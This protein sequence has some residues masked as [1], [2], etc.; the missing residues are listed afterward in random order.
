LAPDAGLLEVGIIGENRTKRMS[1][2]WY[3][4]LWI[5]ESIILIQPKYIMRE[6]ANPLLE[7]LLA[8]FRETR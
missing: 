6:E 8:H 3:M 4:L 2:M 5:W 1:V 7:K